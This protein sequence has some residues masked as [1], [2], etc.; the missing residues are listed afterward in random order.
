MYNN[1]QSEIRRQLSYYNAMPL[2]NINWVDDQLSS[3]LILEAFEYQ[4][5]LLVLVLPDSVFCF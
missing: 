1:T 2:L 3:Y 5:P 4:L